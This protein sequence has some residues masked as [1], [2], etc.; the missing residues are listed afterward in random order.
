[1]AA[2]FLTTDQA[3]R[4][5]Y[6]ETAVVTRAIRRAPELFPRTLKFRGRW[7]VR[8]E[9]LHGIINALDWADGSDKAANAV[10]VNT[11]TG[12]IPNID[13]WLDDHIVL[14]MATLHRR[15]DYRSGCRCGLGLDGIDPDL[16]ETEKFNYLFEPGKTP[17]VAPFD[18]E[19][20]K[21]ATNER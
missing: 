8:A 20:I 15:V 13:F 1:M 17:G 3:A 11:L 21:E 10:W 5:L 19:Y 4:I 6:V 7:Q 18:P 9:D 16:V 12:G 14:D 2:G